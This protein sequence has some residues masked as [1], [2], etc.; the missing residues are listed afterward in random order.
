MPAVGQGVI[1]LQTRKNDTQTNSIVSKAN[2]KLTYDQAHLER[3]LLKGIQ[4]D[5]QTKVAAHAT[6][7]NP[8][9]L[10]AVFY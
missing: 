6:G 7:S 10:K 9:Q 2:H 3:A 8:I 1:A 4:G 5:C